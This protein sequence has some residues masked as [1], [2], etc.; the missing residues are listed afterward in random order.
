MTVHVRVVGI[1]GVEFVSE[2]GEESIHH[3]PPSLTGHLES[4]VLYQWRE[5]EEGEGERKK[6]LYRAAYRNSG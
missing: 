1:G 5:E 6:R 3:L 4:A 2:R